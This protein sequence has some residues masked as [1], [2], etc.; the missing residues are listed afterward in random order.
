MAGVISADGDN[1]YGIS[2]GLWK[3]RIMPLKVLGKNRCGNVGDT[4]QA[5]EYALEK[6]ARIIVIGSGGGGFHQAEFDAIR[7]ARDAGVLVL[8]PAGNNRSDNDVVPVYPA[9][10]DLSNVVSVG[11]TDMNDNLYFLSNY[12]KKTVD[13]GAPGDCIYTTLPSAGFGLQSETNF[14]CTSL[15][16]S[17]NFDYVSG[18]SMATAVAAGGAGLLMTWAPFLTPEEVK[19]AL[20]AGSD[21]KVALKDVFASGGRMNIGNS[22][23]G[24]VRSSFTGGRGGNVGCGGFTR[25]QGSAESYR[26]GFLSLL[27]V[28][29]PILIS[30]RNFRRLLLRL[31]HRPFTRLGGILFVMVFITFLSPAFGQVDEGPGDAPAG[32]ASGEHPEEE[33]PEEASSVVRPPVSSENAHHFLS[34]KT[35]FHFY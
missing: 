3:S 13:L 9:G 11:A 18:S 26:S 32:E 35:G 5:I 23:V 34:I 6:R 16:F 15:P 29:I 17:P 8:A 14:I 24:E 2:G 25:H 4:V 7:E 28:V 19:A 21:P 10:Y 12:G 31:I 22:I 20:V 30:N 1:G 27:L 33:S